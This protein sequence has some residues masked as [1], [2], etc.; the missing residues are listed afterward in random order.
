MSEPS[1]RRKWGKRFALLALGLFILVLLIVGGVFAF[2][3]TQSGR[4]YTAKTIMNLASSESLT[5]KL[6]ELDSVMPWDLRLGAFSLADADG[7][8]LEGGGLHIQCTVLDALQGKYTFPRI[9]LGR[10]AFYR[11]PLAD[12]TPQEQKPPQELSIP[13]LPPLRIDALLVKELLLRYGEEPQEKTFTISGA[14]KPDQDAFL[15]DLNIDELA[16]TSGDSTSDSLV[17]Q[18]RWRES[19]NVLDIQTNYTEGPG[20][21]LSAGLG[22]AAPASIALNGVGPLN[23]WQGKARFA[24]GE[25]P[26][27]DANISIEKQE[28]LQLGVSG[29]FMD[30]IDL[31][32]PDAKRYLGGDVNFSLGVST[33]FPPPEEREFTLKS[34]TVDAPNVHLAADAQLK[35]G[36]LKAL[37]DIKYLNETLWEELS[38][39]ALLGRP[40]ISIRLHGVEDEAQVNL[41]CA[42]GDLRFGGVTG[43]KTTFILTA[44]ITKPLEM[45]FDTLSAQGGLSVSN[46][47]SPPGYAL[48]DSLNT[49]FDL[50]LE[51]AQFVHIKSFTLR[52]GENTVDASG[53][54]ELE[55]LDIQAAV[56]A[57]IPQAGALLA[58]DS[59]DAALHL[60]ADAKGR[61]KS[62]IDFDLKGALANL[63]GLKDP[64]PE[65][66]GDN[67]TFAV[68]ARLTEQELILHE[69]KV[70]SLTNVLA[71]GRAGLQD[72]TIDFNLTVTPPSNV[73][74][75]DAVSLSGLR[76]L[77]IS[78]SGALE[79]PEIGLSLTAKKIIQGKQTFDNVTLKL[80]GYAPPV[81]DVDL[82]PFS[83]TLASSQLKAALRTQYSLAD[84]GLRLKDLNL[85]LPG[86]A[87]TGAL[88]LDFTDSLLDGAANIKLTNLAELAPLTGMN[89]GGA[90]VVNLSFTPGEKKQKAK[91]NVALQKV[92]FEDTTLAA[93]QADLIS[94]DLFNT[95][96]DLTLKLNNATAGDAR[97]ETAQTTVALRGQQFDIALSAKGE[98][99]KPFTIAVKTGLNLK[100]K[101]TDI[102]LAALQGGYAGVPLKLASPAAISL[103]GEAV[104]VNGLALNIGKS[105]L[106]VN[107]LWDPKN[108]D[109][110]VALTDFSLGDLAPFGVNDLAG[111]IGLNL[112]LKG[113]AHRPVVDLQVQGRKLAWKKEGAP[114]LPLLNLDADIKA[115]STNLNAKIALFEPKNQLVQATAALPINLA[116][117]PFVFELSEKSPLTGAVQGGLDLDLVETALG[118]S[119]QLLS[120][121]AAYNFTLGGAVQ[122][123]QL[124]GELTLNNAQYENLKLGTLL[125]NINMTILAQGPSITLKTLS[126]N[127]GGKG[128]IT[129]KGAFSLEGDTPYEA[130][131][132]LRGLQA[133][134]MDIFHCTLDG[135]L[136]M[137]GN[138]KGADL[139]GEIVFTESVIELPKS[140]PPSIAEVEVED[141][142][143]QYPADEAEEQEESQSSFALTMDLTARIPGRFVVRGLGLDSEWS[144]AFYL[145][146]PTDDLKVTGALNAQRGHFDFLDKRFDLEQG[147]LSMGGEFPP[148]PVINVVCTA[149]AVDL[150]AS[151]QVAGPVD[152]LD[153]NLSSIPERPQNE[154]MSAVL[155]G[156]SLDQLSPMQAIRLAQALDR[157]SGKSNSGLTDDLLKGVQDA[158]HVDEL[159]VGQGQSGGATLEAGA[160]LSDDVY[161]K[162]AKG[163]NPEDDAVAV[164]VE[165]T[166][167]LG[168]EGEVGGDDSGGVGVN[169]KIDY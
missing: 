144:G 148:S 61:M 92:H 87:L 145:K 25:A 129:G 80:D 141:P 74:I 81:N 30:S 75:P 154:I 55:N 165:L 96:G 59:L 54:V 107:G 39:G 118:M 143:A 151:I 157:F 155:F 44:A 7:V 111:A 169:W 152:A 121:K 161:L 126:A 60:K 14:C 95:Y 79:Q 97:I 146:G 26:L 52:N 88:R 2:L 31:L 102:A 140:L 56:Q 50:D 164:E 4:D 58:L 76:P 43:G 162:G 106:R 131:L 15:L 73:K 45:Q 22:A 84:N 168:I 66:V 150:T 100:E 48:A 132:A 110:R 68:N 113:A 133:V 21:L 125:N 8:W 12:E 153:L 91:I 123:P 13:A 130:S 149:Q 46:L 115:T 82:A 98:A 117:T 104:S 10:L 65:L 119:D 94:G 72:N 136:K 11:P 139:A 35:E 99:D 120:G 70:S 159:S 23:N 109:V 49:E 67:I 17:L 71:K 6:E 41:D 37:A 103:E 135:D 101:S 28:T 27:L 134:N 1:P 62:G 69:T 63:Q 40:T 18:A 33:P 29:V 128:V 36:A 3:D 89:F 163:I 93:V 86:V 34:L 90:G 166:P 167:N 57:D 108:S 116:L 32:P 47:T 16:D 114:E 38:G 160:Y 147:L 78:A 51:K 83:L 122:S 85:G 156:R 20:G 77:Q 127:D 124:D 42:L 5:I 142:D 9:E 158:L 137:S 24:I 64:V 19:D 53:K 105:L 112:A 138:A